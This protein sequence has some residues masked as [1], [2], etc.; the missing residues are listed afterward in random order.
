MFKVWGPGVGGGKVVEEGGGTQS[1]Q[2][3]YTFY[4][5][6]LTVVGGTHQ[7]VMNIL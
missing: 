3:L 7:R 5:T 6:N 1:M 2:Q 4:G